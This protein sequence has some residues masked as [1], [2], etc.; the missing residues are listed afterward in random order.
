MEHGCSGIPW[1]KALKSEDKNRFKEIC[2]TIREDGRYVEAGENDNLIVQKLVANPD[3][4]GVFA[5]A[6]SSR[7]R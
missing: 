4:F 6:S 7:T 2:H 1:I 5:T 3:A